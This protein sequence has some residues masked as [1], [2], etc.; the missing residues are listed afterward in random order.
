MQQ[1]MASNLLSKVETGNKTRA[2]NHKNQL[3]KTSWSFL[4][5]AAYPKHNAS[6]TK[7]SGKI[8]HGVM[9]ILK[10]NR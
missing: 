7:T 4:T 8:G 2:K 3:G 10:K 6:L 5:D 1:M 9:E